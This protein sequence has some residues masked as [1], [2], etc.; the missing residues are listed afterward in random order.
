M[1]SLETTYKQ[2]H[3]LMGDTVPVLPENGLDNILPYI[4]EVRGFE[5]IS[6]L[7]YPVEYPFCEKDWPQ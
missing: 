3:S 6:S 1:V 7:K 4:N 2:H 5:A